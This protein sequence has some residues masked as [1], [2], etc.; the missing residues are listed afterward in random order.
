MSKIRQTFIII[1]IV[2]TAGFYFNL[3]KQYSINDFTNSAISTENRVNQYIKLSCDYIDILSIYGNEYMTSNTHDTNSYLKDLNYNKSNNY[4]SLDSASVKGYSN[5]VGNLTGKGYIPI[6]S[7]SIKELNLA[8]N[9][10][11]YFYSIYKT[12]PG[13]TWIYYTSKKGFMNIYPWIS[14]KE[15]VYND[16]LLEKEFF[17]GGLPNVNKNKSHFWTPIYNDAAGQGNMVTISKSIYNNQNF[18]GVVSIDITVNKLNYILQSKYNAFLL[19]E[20]NQIIGS[21][22]DNHEMETKLLNLNDLL[23]EYTESQLKA[24]KDLP[25]DKVAKWQDNYIYKLSFKDAPWALYCILPVDKVLIETF[26][27]TLPIFIIGAFL[28]LLSYEIYVRKKTETNL[29]GLVKELALTQSLL[30]KSASYDFLTS[31]LNRRGFFEKFSELLAKTNNKELISIIITDIDFFKR[32][33]DIYGHS[34]GDTVLVNVAHIIKNSIN[35][36]D[37]IARWGGEEFLIVLHNTKY[38]EAINK[39]EIL[40]TSIANTIIKHKEVE[41]KLSMTFG[42]SKY[43]DSIGIEQ[44]ISNADK[45]LYYGKNN[46]RNRVDGYEDLFK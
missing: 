8:L 37:I 20:Y 29:K 44:C 9:Y 25:K 45:A 34:I 4:Y 22:F 40:R 6:D 14:S 13:I 32:I 16:V 33:N 2:F 31:L 18:L 27:S 24:L 23:S 12:L 28:L 21:N 7:E 38:E 1:I 42:V 35:C 5:Y 17:I 15:F 39:A 26:I 10:N 19:N 43:D 46:G 3:K 11:K 30:H 41:I 36:N